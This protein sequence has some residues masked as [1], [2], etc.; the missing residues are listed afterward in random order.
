M[1]L[2]NQNQILHLTSYADYAPSLTKHKDLRFSN[3]KKEEKGKIIKR[4]IK[5]IKSQIRHFRNEIKRPILQE[6]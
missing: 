3:L 1:V 4:R 6:F 5:P 2:F